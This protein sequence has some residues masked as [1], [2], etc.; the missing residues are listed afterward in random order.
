M[1][2]RSLLAAGLVSGIACNN[3]GAGRH[4]SG[5]GEHRS[6]T[7][8]VFA[9]ASLTEAFTDLGE[10]F[11]REHPGVDV[12]FNF[13]GSQS[14]RTQIEN[15]AEPEV[16]ASANPR[17]MEE[18]VAAE[19]V[20]ASTV[21]AH[22]R[23]VIAVPPQNP[24]RIRSLADL[25]RAERLVLAGVNVPAGA[26]AATVIDAVDTSSPGFA[27]RVAARVVSREM[28][29]RQVLQKVALGE[30]DAA[31]VYATDAASAGDRIRTVAIPD[32]VNVIADYPIAAVNGAAKPGLG[33]R[34]V[35]FVRSERGREILARRG[36]VP[37]KVAVAAGDE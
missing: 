20:G 37:A 22:N 30:A 36:F 10:A 28:H 27:G 18:L 2:V 24:A 13:A 12:I 11:E 34:F 6:G 35:D 33:Q 1:I 16:F 7:V 8:T 5:D 26:Y 32:D 3:T 31:M 15:G 17:H 4:S 25:P 14:L 21:F 9:A 29:V 23:M 19:L